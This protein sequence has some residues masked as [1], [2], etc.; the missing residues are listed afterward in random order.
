MLQPFL[1]RGK[2][3]EKPA[4]AWGHLDVRVSSESRTVTLDFNR[5]QCVEL[6]IASTTGGPRTVRSEFRYHYLPFFN[7]NLNTNTNTNAIIYDVK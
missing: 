7:L 3:A 4:T 2:R 1:V 6:R 5:G